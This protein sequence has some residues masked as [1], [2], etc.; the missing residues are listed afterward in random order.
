VRFEWDEVK[1]EANGKKHKVS[2]E[3]AS[4][5][6]DDPHLLVFIERVEDGEERWHAIGYVS[7]SLLFLTAVHTCLEGEVVRIVSARPEPAPKGTCMLKQFSEE[8]LLRRP[9]SP[10]QKAEVLALMDVRDEDIDTSDIPEVKELPPGTVPGMFTA[11][12]PSG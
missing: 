2:F 5:V 7:G 6:F 12:T 1:N 4:L 9:L 11:D 10:E 8:E 3:V